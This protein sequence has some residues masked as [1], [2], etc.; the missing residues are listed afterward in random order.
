[1]ASI[2]DRTARVGITI[3]AVV[4]REAAAQA[5]AAAAFPA[6]IEISPRSRSSV[7]RVSRRCSNPRALN[8]P[9]F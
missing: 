8:E 5:R 7:E 1:M 4:R 3:N 6:E 9:V 2:F